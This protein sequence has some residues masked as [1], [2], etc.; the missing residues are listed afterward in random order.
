MQKKGENTPLY[1]QIY[2]EVQKRIKNGDYKEN[3]LL[4]SEAAL[5]KEFG[6]S[7]IT[8]RRSLQDLELAGFVKIRKGKGAIVQPARKYLDLVAATSFS[9]E[10]ERV[11]E[12]ASSVILKFEE[13]QASGIVCDYLKMEDGTDIYHLKRLRLQNGRI[14][15]INEQFISK[16]TGVI[17]RGDEL[18]ENTSIYALYEEQGFHIS[19]AKETIEAIIPS[20]EMQ[21]ELYMTAGEPLF[22]RERI[23]YDQNNQPLELSINSYK[24]NEYKY[25]ITLRREEL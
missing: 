22:R 24:A 2:K 19:Y 13:I 6:V 15:G 9:Q 16:D 4:P 10:A 7:R 20:K 25:T 1:L 17:I 21:K 14:I 12:R 5:Q 3:E 23:T 8:I 11:G 18:D